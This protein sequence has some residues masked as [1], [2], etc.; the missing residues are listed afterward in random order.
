MLRAA[1]SER[2]FAREM[3]HRV[4]Q[5]VTELERMAVVNN[6]GESRKLLISKR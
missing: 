2:A 6:Q 3:L 4:L 1:P 5:K